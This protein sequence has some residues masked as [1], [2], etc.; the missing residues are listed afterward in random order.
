MKEDYIISIVGKQTINGEQ[1]E[2]ELT[3]I[4]SYITKGKNRYIIYKEYDEDYPKRKIRS[5]LKIEDDK[6]VTMIRNGE[7]PT[8]LML[9]RGKRHL[10]YYNTGYGSLMIGVFADTIKVNLNQDGGTI[11]V[12]YTIDFNSDF[13]SLNELYIKVSSKENDCEGKN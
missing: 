12:R 8:R 7:N 6:I 11:N 1:D 9:E 4:G 3:T 2:I 13:N 10:C 5:T